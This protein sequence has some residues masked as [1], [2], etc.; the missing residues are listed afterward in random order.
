MLVT[1]TPLCVIFST[2]FALFG[3]V[4][5]MASVFDALCHRFMLT[6]D[7][8]DTFCYVSLL[9]SWIPH[10]QR[11]TLCNSRRKKHQSSTENQGFFPTLESCL[12]GQ[13]Y[14]QNIFL[15]AACVLNKES[16]IFHITYFVFFSWSFSTLW[17]NSDI[18]E[19]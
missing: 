15:L 9:I 16:V 8:A 6:Q 2:F 10:T 14:D 12:C 4:V 17:S 7:S 19:K 5:T 18:I 11:D 1:D 13:I 3:I